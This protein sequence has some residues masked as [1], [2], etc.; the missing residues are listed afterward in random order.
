M[1]NKG[2]KLSENSIR[3]NLYDLW[4]GQIFL[5]MTPKEDP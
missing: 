2:I 5:K 1:P 4:L 3:E